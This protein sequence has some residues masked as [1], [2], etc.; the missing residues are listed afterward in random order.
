MKITKYTHAC[1][2]LERDGR[3][4]VIDPGNFS[5]PEAV[6]GADAVIITHSHADHLEPATILAAYRA[7]RDLVVLAPADA[8]DELAR[9]RRRSDR[10]R[11]G[12][13]ARRGRFLRRDVR[14]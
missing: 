9:A 5:E 4:L 13:A 8:A 1:V 12:G 3:V 14:R 7:N 6:D 2:R 10:G 11:T